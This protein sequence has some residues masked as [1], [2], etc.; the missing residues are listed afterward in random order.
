MYFM[1]F[2]AI[3]DAIDACKRREYEKTLDILIT[4]QRATEGEFIEE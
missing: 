1:L 3:S 2:N 4:A